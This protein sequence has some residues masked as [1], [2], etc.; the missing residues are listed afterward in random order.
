M[1][2]DSSDMY[3]MSGPHAGWVVNALER[4]TYLKMGM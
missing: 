3:M 2:H 1:I 4:S